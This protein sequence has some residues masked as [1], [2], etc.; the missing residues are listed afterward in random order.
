MTDEQNGEPQQKLIYELAIF[1]QQIQNLQQQIQAVET[2]IIDMNSLTF[3]L[4]ELVGKSGKEILAPIGRGIFTRAKL[5]SEDLIVDIGGKNFVKKDIPET[6]ELITKQIT[7][8]ENVKKELEEDL[9][10]IG[11]KLKRFYEDVN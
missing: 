7:K 2:A 3:G 1:E 11:E 8:L 9:E 10:L 5:V 4:D 6:K